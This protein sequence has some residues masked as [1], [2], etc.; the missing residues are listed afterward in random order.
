MPTPQLT[1]VWWAESGAAVNNPTFIWAA[2]TALLL[3]VALLAQARGPQPMRA[4]GGAFAMAPVLVLA[5]IDLVWS[6]I[7]LAPWLIGGAGI[8]LRACGCCGRAG[9]AAE[10]HF[11]GRGDRPCHPR[12]RPE[13]EGLGRKRMVDRCRGPCGAAM[14]LERHARVSVRGHA[15]FTVLR[16]LAGGRT[17]PAMPIIVATPI[18]PGMGPSAWRMASPA[19]PEM[20]RFACQLSRSASRRRR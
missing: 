9:A 18:T 10:R 17:P 20:V 5:V 15:A 11:N 19:P 13:P 3:G 12:R 6:E 2:G 1:L 14:L 16:L 8:G 7:N 4:L